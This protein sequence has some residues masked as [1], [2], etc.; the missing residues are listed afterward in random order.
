M[1]E[2]TT[3]RYEKILIAVITALSIII[4]GILTNIDK[5]SNLVDKKSNTDKRTSESIVQPKPDN[6]K[7]Y[8]YILH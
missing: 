7:Q 4:G 1:P 3:F 8:K 6:E 2:E 5:I